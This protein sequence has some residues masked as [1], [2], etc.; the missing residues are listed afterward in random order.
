VYFPAYETG[1]SSPAPG[2]LAFDGIEVAES[3]SGCVKRVSRFVEPDRFPL[4]L[5]AVL[6][7]T[8]RSLSLHQT[9]RDWE[10]P[11]PP[12]G[13]RPIT[14]WA[15]RDLR[16]HGSAILARFAAARSGLEAAVDYRAPIARVDGESR[17]DVDG[18][19]DS[20][21]AYLVAWKAM[22]V[23]ARQVVV[24]E[25]RLE[26]GG[27]TVGLVNGTGW[28]ARQDVTEPGP[29]RVV[30]QAPAQGSYQVV[31]AN[32]LDDRASRNRFAIARIAVVDGEHD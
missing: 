24:A 30:V 8:W 19:P 4:L 2:L 29:F 12:D 11:S 9:L 17:V 23:A 16:G 20:S 28:V 15:P 7:G 6:P 3:E 25:G 31:V 27:L 18:R 14:Y 32:R 26:R 10:T 21:G 5:A 22:P 13:G 1:G